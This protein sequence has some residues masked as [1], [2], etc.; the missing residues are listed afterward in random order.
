V[1]PRTVR[2]SAVASREELADALQNLFLAEL[3]HP[4]APL[5]VVTPWISDVGVID[6][7]SGAFNGL[8]SDIP[9]RS[10]RLSEVL[11]LQMARGGQVVVGCRPDP[12]NVAFIDHLT[13]TAQGLNA[14]DR[15]RHQYAEE[16]HEKGIL[17]QHAMLSGSM[18]LTYN[19][20]RRLEESISITDD[21]N[22]MARA[23]HAYEDRWGSP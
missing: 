14:E 18:N 5:W 19:G 9:L 4:S 16:L 2:T 11:A 13:F 23:R 21:V 1:S 7:R 6:N 12:H 15:F 10:L 3:F 22:A 17:S 8:A 20:L